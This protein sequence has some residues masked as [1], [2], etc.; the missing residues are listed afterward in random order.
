MLHVSTSV[1]C[2][3]MVWVLVFTEDNQVCDLDL[4]CMLIVIREIGICL[5]HAH[6]AIKTLLS[7]MILVLTKSAKFVWII[8]ILRLTCLNHCY[9]R[10]V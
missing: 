9:Y 8:T 4:S 7:K 2:I 3:S 5:L 1:D 6:R 10:S